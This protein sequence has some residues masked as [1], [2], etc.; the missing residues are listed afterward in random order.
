MGKYTKI[1]IVIPQKRESIKNR[2]E[3]KK[4][5]DDPK[6]RITIQNNLIGDAE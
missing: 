6:T 3:I 4:L 5:L 2:R 1:E